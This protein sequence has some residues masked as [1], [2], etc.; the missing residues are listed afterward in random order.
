MIKQK[1]L[2]PMG[3]DEQGTLNVSVEGK[4]AT[5]RHTVR[6]DSGSSN[7]FNLEWRFDF[8]DVSQKELVELAT[9]TVLIRKQGEWRKAQDRMNATVWDNVVFAVRD[10]LDSKRKTADPFQRLMSQIG[11]MSAGEKAAIMKTLQEAS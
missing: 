1:N 9:R 8:A 4:I 5:V 7:R 11:K 3:D 10:I 2:K 6:P